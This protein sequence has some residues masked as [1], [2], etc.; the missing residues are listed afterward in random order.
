MYVHRQHVH[1]PRG[2]QDSLADD[3]GEEEVEH[4]EEEGSEEKE[5]EDRQQQV[6]GEVVRELAEHKPELRDEG[7]LEGRKIVVG[8]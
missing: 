6:L 2:R 1:A 5:H 7:D 4:E 3:D 8:R